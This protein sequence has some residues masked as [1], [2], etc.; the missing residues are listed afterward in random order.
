M[1]SAANYFDSVFQRQQAFLDDWLTRLDGTLADRIS[2]L[3]QTLG[4]LA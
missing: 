3:G 1:V 2:D 4:P